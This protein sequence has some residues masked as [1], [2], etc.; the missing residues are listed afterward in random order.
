MSKTFRGLAFLTPFL[1][2][3]AAGAQNSN[4]QI[5]REV[6]IPRHLQDGEETQHPSEPIDPLR[7]AAFLG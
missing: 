7:R 4:S 1:L 6:A 3:M 2:A 5:G